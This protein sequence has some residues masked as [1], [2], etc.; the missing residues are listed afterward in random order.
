MPA[1]DIIN[2]FYWWAKAQSAN[3]F[4]DIFKIKIFHAN[5]DIMINSNLIDLTGQTS[6]ESE[7]KETKET[8]EDVM[9]S[10]FVSFVSFC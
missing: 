7:Q 6:R 5:W 10:V 9:I 1:P 2:E 4:W 3:T 8:K